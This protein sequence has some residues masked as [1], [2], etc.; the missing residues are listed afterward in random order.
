MLFRSREIRRRNK[1]KKELLLAILAVGL[2]IAALAFVA[3][4]QIIQTR[5]LRAELEVVQKEKQKY[6]DELNKIKQLEQQQA[7]LETRI[8]IIKELKK[9]AGVAV[10]VMDDVASHTP[11]DRMWLTK[12]TQSSSGQKNKHRDTEITIIPK[13]SAARRIQGVLMAIKG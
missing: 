13:K 4:V 5:G 12:L 9:N 2:F 6:N 11:P 10:H 3:I 7:L 8:A 1:A